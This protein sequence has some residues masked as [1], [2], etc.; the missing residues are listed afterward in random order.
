MAAR[1]GVRVTSALSAALVVAVVLVAAGVVLVQL[2]GNS[3]RRDLTGRADVAAVATDT[4]VYYLLL[5]VPVLIVVVGLVIYFFTGRVLRAVEIIRARAASASGQDTEPASQDEVAR[6]TETMDALLA[7]LGEARTAQQRFAAA[8][9][10]LRAPLATLTTCLDQFHRGTA[11]RSTLTVLRTET[12]RLG[13]VIESLLAA[14]GE[15]DLPDLPDED[16]EDLVYDQNTT[17][18]AMSGGFA[19]ARPTPPP[20]E[21][22]YSDPTTV[23]TPLERP[24]RTRQPVRDEDAK[25]DP[26]TAPRGIPAARPSIFDTQR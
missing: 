19:A 3:V 11:D 17:P 24:A 23:I 6:L 9:T 16:E 2:V 20:S 18:V 15:P 14:A 26:I 1:I 7:R 5:S 10:D 25:E 8:G 4:L 21:Y 12:E 22:D 13:E